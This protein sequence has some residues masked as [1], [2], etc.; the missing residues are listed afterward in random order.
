MALTSSGKPTYL[1]LLNTVS[2]AETRAHCYLTEWA[3]VT[4][5]EEV[6]EVLLTV[7]AREGE[8]GMS[9]AKRINELGYQLRPKPDERDDRA[10]EI[11]RAE[12]SDLE[13]FEALGLHKLDSG[14]EPDVFDNLFKD[15]TIDIRTGE[16]LGRYIAEE[17]ESARLFRSCY[18]QLC[19]ARDAEAKVN[20]GKG[21]TDKKT[22]KAGKQLAALDTKVDA[23]TRAVD[24]LRQ[25]VCAQSMP[26]SAG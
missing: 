25:I 2:L 9:F 11:V 3:S 21:A 26:A 12:C 4:K 19:A 8:H 18:E 20:G 23:L 16:M 1:G 17:R 10:L 22:D 5:S 24:E 13:K 6:R 15:H 7:A 14:D